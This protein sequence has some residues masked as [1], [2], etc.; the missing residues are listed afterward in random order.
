MKKLKFYVPLPE[1]ILKRMKDTTWRV[2]DD[3][4]LSAGDELSLCYGDTEKKDEEF[5]K[6]KIVRIKETT[7]KELTEEDKVG[8]KKYK[9]EEEMYKVYSNYYKTNIM[10]DTK[11]KIV[12]FKLMFR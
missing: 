5:A 12:K 1:L 7:F 10:P 4:N 8:H 11:L 2:N 9:T 3:K 6:A